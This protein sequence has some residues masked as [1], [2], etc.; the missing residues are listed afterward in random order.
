VTYANGSNVFVWWA[1]NSV[2]TAMTPSTTF[3]R[4]PVALSD[5]AVYT[6][7]GVLVDSGGMLRLSPPSVDRA[8][9]RRFSAPTRPTPSSRM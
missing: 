1:K 4:N 3:S 5:A 6:A 2:L 8:G 9:Q 7:M